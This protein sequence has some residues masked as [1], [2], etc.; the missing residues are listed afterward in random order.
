MFS[1]SL[2]LIKKYLFALFFSGAKPV[3]EIT[4]LIPNNYLISLIF[5]DNIVIQIRIQS[6]LTY[7]NTLILNF[8]Y[9]IGS[10]TVLGQKA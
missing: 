10:R 7:T 9:R 8:V 2:G 5:L 3:K 4:S 1:Q 6:I